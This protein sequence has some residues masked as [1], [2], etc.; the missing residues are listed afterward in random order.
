MLVLVLPLIFAGAAQ[1]AAT[2]YAIPTDYLREP[3]AI[4]SF[5][6]TTV[7]EVA[8]FLRDSVKRG[9]VEVI[10]RTAGGRQMNAVC[11]GSPRQ[12]R[13]TTTFSGSLGVGNVRTFRGPG[14]D[15]R[16][17][18][19]M[20]AV[21]GGEWEGIAGIV[22]LLSAIETGKDLRG[23]P[24]PRIAEIAA[25]LDRVILIPIVNLDGRA[26]VPLRMIAHR[27]NDYFVQEYFNTGGRP[28]GKL[29]GWPQVK[30]FIPLDFTRTQF[31]GGYP[32]DAGVN[33]QHDD[34]LSPRRQPETQ[35]LLDLA[36]R[37]LPDLILNMHTGAQFIQPLR[38]FVEPVLIPRWEEIYRRVRGRLA[39][40][41]LQ[42][43]S[44]PA[45]AGDPAK[46]RLNTYNLDTALSL[47]SGAL[48]FVVESPAHSFSTSRRDG[49]PF[50][51]SPD[52][53]LDAQLTTHEE[54][55]KYLLETGGRSQWG[56][57]K[58]SGR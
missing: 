39:R 34:F 55:M 6:I 17:Y 54:A 13:G 38:P 40:L 37:E 43:S 44:D 33:I 30:E 22:N 27:G 56:L 47:N 58:S 16:V 52:D 42:A 35:A 50:Q 49:Q 18:M 21:H 48:A 14:H 2:R 57:E 3:S 25:A 10:G 15:K 26:R 31:P 9:K 11:Y 36:G 32:N 7:D 8:A 51:H 5:W 20:A 53:I 1:P 46:E 45:I 29:I 19:A 24:W 23:K 28:D 41:G 12:G 4:P